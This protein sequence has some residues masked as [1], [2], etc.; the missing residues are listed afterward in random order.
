MKLNKIFTT[1]IIASQALAL[2]Q[3]PEA[4]AFGTK[5]RS[6]L[7]IRQDAPPQG[8]QDASTGDAMAN[9][10]DDAVVADKA[11]QA[12]DE[13]WGSLADDIKNEDCTNPAVKDANQKS[14]ERWN[15]LK[16]DE[17]FEVANSAYLEAHLNNTLNIGYT[18]YIS[19]FFNGPEGWSCPK[20]ANQ[21]CTNTIQCDDV[22]HPAG[23]FI[24]NSISVMHAVCE[25]RASLGRFAL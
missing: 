15:S 6:E 3:Q 18:E 5:Q 17:V 12:H 22:N 14:N 8:A 13:K 4:M 7:E 19:H 16:A 21:P 11:R 1:G 9:D 20:I 23:Y 24:L 2:P 25:S 10:A